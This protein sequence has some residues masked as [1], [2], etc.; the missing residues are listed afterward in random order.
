MKVKRVNKTLVWELERF[1]NVLPL[2]MSEDGP[3]PTVEEVMSSA[4]DI[5]NKIDTMMENDRARNQDL[6]ELSKEKS[7]S[8]SP[9]RQDDNEIRA[10]TGPGPT[11]VVEESENENGDLKLVTLYDSKEN[12]K[13]FRT[14]DKISKAESG[15]SQQ[16][17]QEI[18]EENQRLKENEF[19]Y[20][21]R[22]NNLRDKLKQQKMKT[23]EANSNK[24][25]YFSDRNELEDFFLNCIEEVK[26]DIVKRKT[27]QDSYPHKKFNRSSSQNFKK[28]KSL[29]GPK[30]EQFTKT[31]KKKVIELLISN[32]QVLLFLYEH[33]FPYETQRPQSVKTLNIQKNIRPTSSQPSL[34]TAHS[35]VPPQLLNNL[36]TARQTND[37]TTLAGPSPNIM[38]AR[39]LPHPQTRAKTAKG[40]GRLKP[41]L[42]SK[43]GT[44][45]MFQPSQLQFVGENSTTSLLDNA[46][47][48]QTEYGKSPA[49]F[50]YHSINRRLIGTPSDGNRPIK[51]TVDTFGNPEYPV[52]NNIGNVNVN[53]NMGEAVNTQNFVPPKPSS[54]KR[55][56]GSGMGRSISMKDFTRVKPSKSKK[57]LKITA[58]NI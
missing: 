6:E 50:S 54:I 22:I 34:T 17:I 21:G 5:G 9:Y 45:N 27:K 51:P 15:Y 53:I 49:D 26:K 30:Y 36:A 16:E 18:I 28:S 58:R 42:I 33:L 4:R 32:E 25:K 11:T 38:D 3:A 57:R 13:Q 35:F 12:S 7:L 43:T 46:L 52:Q 55:L 20:Q 24:V 56:N 31:D 8:P 47:N 19:K 44:S 39:F 40:S 14:Y 37:G 10:I 41:G 2:A 29:K 1:K 23:I 48:R